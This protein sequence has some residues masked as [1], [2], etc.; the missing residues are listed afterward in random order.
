MQCICT[1][2][3]WKAVR[4][5]TRK[6]LLPPDAGLILAAS[7]SSA[8]GPRKAGCT[9]RQGSTA[10]CVGT[11]DCPPAGLQVDQ[12]SPQPAALLPAARPTT[13]P[14]NPFDVCSHLPLPQCM[15]AAC[16]KR[17]AFDGSP[18]TCYCPVYKA[19]R[20]LIGSSN[21]AQDS[22]A[23]NLPYVAR[24]GLDSAAAGGC[25]RA[26]GACSRHACWSGSPQ[27]GLAAW[28]PPSLSVQRCGRRLGWRRAAQQLS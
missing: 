28:R 24:C 10:P 3:P 14:L 26:L 21:C 18:I 11:A 2:Q 12:A 19:K 9:H 13:T 15:T 17:R 22:C 8:S 5:H 6:S 7:T 23:P 1:V 25:L 27:Q 16:F 4:G 20:Y